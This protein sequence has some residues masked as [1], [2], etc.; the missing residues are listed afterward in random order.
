MN[1]DIPA[2]LTTDVHF[3]NNL[4]LQIILESA[5]YFQRYSQGTHSLK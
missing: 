4:L 3:A 2:I 5:N 1:R